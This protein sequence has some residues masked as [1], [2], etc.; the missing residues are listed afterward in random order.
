ML[1][2]IIDDNIYEDFAYYIIKYVINL[3]VTR[4]S[5]DY[6]FDN[7]MLYYL[8]DRYI[9]S[10]DIICVNIEYIRRKLDMNKIQSVIKF[11]YPISDIQRLV[12]YYKLYNKIPTIVDSRTSFKIIKKIVDKKNKN[13]LSKSEIDFIEK[14]IIIWEWEYDR[15]TKTG[16]R[17]IEIYEK[18]KKYGLDELDVTQKKLYNDIMLLLKLNKLSKY[19]K[20]LFTCLT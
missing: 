18:I 17:Y 2:N 5:K 11:M 6:A 4:I 1:Q 15:L 9:L 3:N 7:H 20:S 14:E 16:I 19:F 13:L 12:K 10:H 8:V